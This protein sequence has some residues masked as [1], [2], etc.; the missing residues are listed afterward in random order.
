MTTPLHKNPCPG[1]HDEIY[2]FGR[3]FLEKYINFTFFYPKSTSPWG[4]GHEINNFLFLYPTD[5]TY[6]I[7][8]RLAQ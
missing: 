2:N 6:I 7:W 5:A 3:P 1:S 8:L 4:E